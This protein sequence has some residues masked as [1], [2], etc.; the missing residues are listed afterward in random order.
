SFAA[1]L[2]LLLL[3]RDPRRT[4]ALFAPAA[5]VPLA[6]FLLTNY[7]AIGELKPAYDKFGGPWYEYEG[8]HWK[9]APPG[10]VKPGIDWAG[11]KETRAEYAFHVLLGHHGLLSLSPIFLLAFV[12]MLLGMGQRRSAVTDE[13]HRGAEDAPRGEPLPWIVY[14]L[15]LFL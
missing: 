3:W 11:Q 1:A 8:S 15:T 14:P 12:G 7:L 6:A 4:L 5:A 10:K 2:A 9:P 13:D